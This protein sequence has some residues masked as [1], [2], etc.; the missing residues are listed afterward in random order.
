[1]AEKSD[2]RSCCSRPSLHRTY[3]DQN[4]PDYLELETASSCLTQTMRYPAAA[5]E[6]SS[7]EPIR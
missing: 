4:Q 5:K 7:L 6:R 1:M 2:L 3:P